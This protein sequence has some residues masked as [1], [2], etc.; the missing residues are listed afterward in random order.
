[1]NLQSIQFK[2]SLFCLLL[3]LFF[4]ISTVIYYPYSSETM[5]T[6][7]SIRHYKFLNSVIQNDLSKQI[8]SLQTDKG[9]SL[10]KK[11]LNYTQSANNHSGVLKIS[12]FDTKLNYLD[13][14]N[15][16]D[17]D[18]I[19]IA[20]QHQNMV[21]LRDVFRMSGPLLSTKSKVLGY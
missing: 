13:G 18:K 2:V 5:A 3:S 21:E 15:T 11:L 17:S 7:I 6:D 4:S 12:I 9:Q 8:Q 14:F 20:F 10:K 19:G 1:M 16:Q